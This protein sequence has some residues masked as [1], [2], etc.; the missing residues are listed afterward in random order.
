M[1]SNHFA[2][3]ICIIWQRSIPHKTSNAVKTLQKQSAA[4]KELMGAAGPA[5]QNKIHI[6]MQKLKLEGPSSFTAKRGRAKL[7]QA[8]YWFSKFNRL[9]PAKKKDQ[10]WFKHQK[11]CWQKQLFFRFL[12][13]YKPTNSKYF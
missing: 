10:K 1:A 6:G 8:P 12:K 9:C 2:P 4:G 3:L 13:M 7:K 5:G 11:S